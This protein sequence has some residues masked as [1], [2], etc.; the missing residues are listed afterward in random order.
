[1]TDNS[2]PS[3][4]LVTGGSRG[5]GW[6]VCRQLAQKGMTVILTARDL[7]KAEMAA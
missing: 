6:E 4:A 3:I 2:T 1:M 5:I 7:V